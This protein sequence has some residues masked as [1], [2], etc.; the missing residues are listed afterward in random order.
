[1]S[2]RAPAS[3]DQPVPSLPTLPRRRDSPATTDL[4]YPRFDCLG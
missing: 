1:M 3:G 4:I 2:L